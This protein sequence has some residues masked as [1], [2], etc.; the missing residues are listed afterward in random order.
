MWAGAQ[1]DG[2]PGAQ[3]TGGSIF[4][5]CVFSEPRAARF[6]PAS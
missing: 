1:R 2:R 4:A 5:T 6:K 3:D